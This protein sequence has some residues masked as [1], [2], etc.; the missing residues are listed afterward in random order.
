MWAFWRWIRWQSELRSLPLSSSLS[1]YPSLVL[2]AR[3]VDAR[4]L[5]LKVLYLSSPAWQPAVLVPGSAHIRPA[6]S[7]LTCLPLKDDPELVCQCQHT[8]SEEWTLT[9]GAEG[10]EE[11]RKGEEGWGRQKRYESVWGHVPVNVVQFENTV[12]MSTLNVFYP[13]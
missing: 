13:H 7:C 2:S 1:S 5:G 4:L 9:T 6:L 3:H 8:T 10:W 11:K 12:Y